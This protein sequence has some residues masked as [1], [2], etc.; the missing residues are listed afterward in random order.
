MKPFIPLIIFLA[1]FAV[2]S[3]A[4]AIQCFANQ[5]PCSANNTEFCANGGTSACTSTGGTPLQIVDP[6]P[7]AAM[8]ACAQN[9][10]PCLHNG[11]ELCATGTARSASVCHSAGATP[12]YVN[13]VAS[14]AAATA[15]QAGGAQQSPTAAPTPSRANNS[16]PTGGLINP[17]GVNSIEELL[18]IVLRAVVQLGSILLV[19]AL[20]WVGFLFVFAQGNPEKISSARQ[21]L[22]WT[23]IGGLLLLGA[24][25]ISLVLQQT[26]NNL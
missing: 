21:A 11:T 10:T 17:I 7:S 4:D 3:S 25:G 6:Q 19:L 15:P 13:S 8:K 20:V 24:Q 26:I 23:V 5:T 9:T 14:A 1:L 22:M 18:S 12:I 2:P 16:Q